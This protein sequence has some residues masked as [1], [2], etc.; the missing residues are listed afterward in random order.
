ME[1]KVSMSAI[2][3]DEER[4]YRIEM[5]I[6][7]DAYGPEEQAIGW[8]CHLDDALDFPFKAVVFKKE[9]FRL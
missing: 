2:K 7:V 1:K 4:E 3:K 8:H 6:I 5:E 9:A